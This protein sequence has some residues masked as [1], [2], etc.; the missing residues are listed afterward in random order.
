MDPDR[1]E[2]EYKVTPVIADMILTNVCFPKP[3]LF[4]EDV[5]VDRLSPP[6]AQRR[7]EAFRLWLGDG[8]H[9]IQGMPC[10]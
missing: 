5:L 7:K 3:N 2:S 6:G 10:A 8:E 1:L 9:C 4:V